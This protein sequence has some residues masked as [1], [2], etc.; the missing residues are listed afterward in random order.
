MNNQLA[1]SVL[2]SIYVDFLVGANNILQQAYIK[3]I[4]CS[5]TKINANIQVHA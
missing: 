5:K 3:K 1:V 4:K 2:N